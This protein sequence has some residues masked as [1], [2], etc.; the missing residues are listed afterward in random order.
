MRK[1]GR[2]YAAVQDEP[3]KSVINVAGREA[4]E[5]EPRSSWRYSNPRFLLLGRI[6]EIVTQE[7]LLVVVPSTA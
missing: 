3:V 7:E 6:I 5:F 1:D 4:P 2:R